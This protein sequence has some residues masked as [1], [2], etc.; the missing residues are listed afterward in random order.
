MKGL[1]MLSGGLLGLFLIFCCSL[2]LPDLFRGVPVPELVQKFEAAAPAAPG[3][4]SLFTSTTLQ[5]A[6]NTRKY[7]E[8][9]PPAAPL[10]P[11]LV[12]ERA[13]LNAAFGQ[14]LEQIDKLHIE[15]AG[16]SFADTE[17]RCS[18]LQA[19]AL[20]ISRNLGALRLKAAWPKD[21]AS[22][23]VSN[24]LITGV[25][26]LMKISGDN[27]VR[28]GQWKTLATNCERNGNWPGAIYYWRRL[29]GWEGTMRIVSG[30]IYTRTANV[31]ILKDLRRV[32]PHTDPVMLV[33]GTGNPP[34]RPNTPQG[35]K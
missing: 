20:K 7:P 16:L 27:Y 18:E 21:A 11:A 3:A 35:A 30:A 24:R 13:T 1:I 26:G 6:A 5:R 4:R 10:T 33:G 29:G 17:K 14:W 22:R 34:S 19:E 28:H 12:A 2:V 15:A 8:L 25:T 9:V 23:D 32:L 31:P